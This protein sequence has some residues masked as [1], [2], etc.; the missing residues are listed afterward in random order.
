MICVSIVEKDLKA[1]LE[2]LKQAERAA[3]MAEIRL[4]ALIEPTVKPIISSSPIP[5]VFTFRDKKEGGLRE[6]SLKERLSF[7]EE[8]IQEGAAWVDLELASGKSAFEKLINVRS[9]QPKIS[10][11]KILASFHD[12]ITTPSIEELK[13]IIYRMKSFGV[14]A[15]KIV[16]MA[17]TMENNISVL[18]LIP[19]AKNELNF[20]LIAFCMGNIGKVSRVVAPLLGAPFTYACLPGRSKAAPGQIEVDV[21]KKI[22]NSL[23][24]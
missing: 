20:P 8:A 15:G 1:V 13:D 19:W 23:Y 24:P 3:D 17:K 9:S 10:Q 6:V 14:D 7:L 22:L 4:D 2:A 5:L 12:F 18:S 11:T 16:T 21:M